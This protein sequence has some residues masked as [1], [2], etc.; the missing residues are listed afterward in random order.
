MSGI[1]AEPWSDFVRQWL[2]QNDRSQAW[3]C[4][5][6]GHSE[7]HFSKQM[8]GHRRIDTYDLAALERVMGLSKGFF[9]ESG[10]AEG[11]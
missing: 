3:L 2:R 10:A 1:V 4:R 6:A 5:Q 11:N 8:R 7:T 9:D